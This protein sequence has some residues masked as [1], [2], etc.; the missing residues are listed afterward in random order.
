M[1]DRLNEYKDKC[2]VLKQ[3]QSNKALVY[4]RLNVAQIFLTILVSAFLTFIGFSGFEKMQEYFQ[5]LHMT[6]SIDFIQMI[7][8]GLLFLLFLVTIFHLVFQ[9]TT[10]QTASEKA[11]YALSSLINEI[12]DI[13]TSKIHVGENIIERINYKYFTITQ[14]I[15]ANTDKEFCRAK[16]DI[17]NKAK[18]KSRANK[19]S[20][21]LSNDEKE[22]YI[23]ELIKDNNLVLEILDLLEKQEK[24][25]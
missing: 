5:I 8:T 12:D 11:V 16:R 17:E 21:T 18:E 7:F 23:I 6:L 2:K 1:A 25:L 3:I 24:E 13:I 10:K 15:P 20:Y 4:K 9:F 14:T 19:Q 22:K